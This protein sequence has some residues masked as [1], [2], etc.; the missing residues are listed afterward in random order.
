METKKWLLKTDYYVQ[1]IMLVGL[2]TLTISVVGIMFAVFGLFPFGV[3]QVGSAL[4]WCIAYRNKKRL[5]YLGVVAFYF[6]A[7]FLLDKYN[8]LN[9]IFPI[10][11]G[12]PLF[13]GVLYFMWTRQDYFESKNAIINNNDHSDLLDA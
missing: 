13:L 8:I 10:F 1:L 12:I 9:D 11:I 4:V 3:W 7:V 6:I 5:Y 2:V